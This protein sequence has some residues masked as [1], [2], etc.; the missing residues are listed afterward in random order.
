MRKDYFKPVRVV[1]IILGEN[2]PFHPHLWEKWGKWDGLGLIYFSPT[3]E[4][5]RDS[6]ELLDSNVAR[7]L[8]PNIKNYPLTNEIV[9][10]ISLP[11]SGIVNNDNPYDYSSYYISVVNLWNHPHHNALPF[12]NSEKNN[13]NPNVGVTY[14]M[15]QSGLAK[16]ETSS[17]DI[18][19]IF[20]DTF[21]EKSDIKTIIPF[22]GDI[23]YEGRY[24]QSIR[25]GSTVTKRKD[26]NS[27]STSGDDGDPITII[28]NGQSSITDT[29]KGW[30]PTIE[31]IN[32]DG[33]SIYLCNNQVIPLKVSSTNL[34]SFNVDTGSVEERDKVI[35]NINNTPTPLES[36][37]KTENIPN[38]PLKPVLPSTSNQSSNLNANEGFL[39]PPP[40]KVYKEGEPN[41][42]NTETQQFIIEKETEEDVEPSTRETTK[43]NPTI[44]TIKDIK[45][46]P[47][48]TIKSGVLIDKKYLPYWNTLKGEALKDGH[49]LELN[50][51]YRTYNEQLSLRKKN[52]IDKTKINDVEYLKNSPSSHFNPLTARPG[53]SEHELGIA[54]DINTSN[55]KSYKWLIDNASK[56][57]FKNKVPSE[58]WHWVYTDKT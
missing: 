41:P 46:N 48:V 18:N 13:I 4:I 16:N 12:P 50:S 11:N 35:V 38:V 52:V 29:N 53:Y 15:I 30:I 45:Q 54:F 55:E 31:D 33:G 43:V 14:E 9:Y 1:H 34:K 10:I 21:K 36:K 24:G 28:R 57:G 44:S 27:W 49:V 7:P 2:D 42:L 20:G 37:D 58:R 3:T 6:N 39:P 19:N 8:Y 22:E 25:F 23:I 40:P 56:F 17:K 26:K 5:T 47:N 51:S 32:N